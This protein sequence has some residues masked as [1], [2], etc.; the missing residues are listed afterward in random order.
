MCGILGE[1][2]IKARPIEEEEFKKLLNLS[3]A[4]G[5]DNQGYY[6]NRKN[7][8]LGFNRLSILDLSKLGNQPIHSLDKQMSMVFNG[9][10]YNY[11]EIKS[12][13][14]KL[15]V[16]IQSTG[17]SEVLI[18]SFRYIG[19]NETLQKIDGMFSIGLFDH[20]LKSLY[21][22]RD[23]SGIKPLHY[24]Y[25]SDYVVFAS[26]YDQIAKHRSFVHNKIDTKVLKLYLSQHFIP[27][28]YGILENTFQVEPGQVVS[29]NK[30]GEK[31]SSLFWEFP[32][33]SEQKFFNFNSGFKKIDRALTHS[34]RS[35]LMSDVPICSF[36][37]GG[38]DSALISFYANKEMEVPLRAI[39]IGSSSSKYD[40]SSDARKY[41]RLIGVQHTIKQM[42]ANDANNLLDDIGKSMR[43][44]FADFSIFPTFL[45]SKI[46]RKNAKV[47]LSGDGADELFFGYERFWS[48]V[49]NQNIQKMPY[50]I[51]YGIYGIDKIISNNEHINGLC[52]F[53]SQSEAHFNLHSR[54]F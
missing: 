5:P 48:I 39:T 3:V 1:F 16:N 54:F 18:N 32:K 49:K 37:S 43:E 20:K 53:P 9:E 24:G 33:Y 36:L 19:I 4:R 25:S 34:V 23:F 29:F 50:F 14:L 12:L 21:L 2:S 11:L 35:E 8:Q 28:P 7:L 15:G 44:P 27:A 52:L 30:F 26:Q 40:E 46:A 41:G 42:T 47:A 22:I 10:I 38:V 51:K 13:L 45:V 31:I 6:S 17:D